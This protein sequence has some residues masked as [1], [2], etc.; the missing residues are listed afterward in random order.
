MTLWVKFRHGGD[1]RCMTALRRKRKSIGGLAM[2]QSAKRRHSHCSRF[3]YTFAKIPL[4]D[5]YIFQGDLPGE[6]TADRA[7]VSRAAAP[8]HPF[9]FS[10]ASMAPSRETGNGKGSEFA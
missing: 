1:V 6:L 10:L 5:L 3:C 9:T 2:S 8:P 4:R 7:E